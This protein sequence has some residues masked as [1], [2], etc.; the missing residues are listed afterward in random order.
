MFPVRAHVTTPT[1]HPRHWGMGAEEL[2]LDQKIEQKTD[3]MK[4]DIKETAIKAA[5]AQ[6][7]LQIGLMFIPVIGWAIG[8]LVA[9]AQFFIGKHYER[10][11]KGVIED[12]MNDIKVFAVRANEQV[13]QTA[14]RIYDEE[15]PNAIRLA[16]SPDP[17]NGLGESFWGK[18]EDKV[19]KPAATAGRKVNM[20]P[21]TLVVK[22]SRAVVGHHVKGSIK[23]LETV[24]LKSTA[25]DVRHYY[26]KGNEIAK[27]IERRTADPALAAK[28]MSGEETVEVAENKINEIKNI[29]YADINKETN[30]AIA[31]LESAEGRYE[32]R[33]QTALALRNDPSVIELRNKFEAQAR[34]AA[35]QAQ[36]QNAKLNA[37]TGPSLNTTTALVGTAL[38][39]G[40][41]FLF[42]R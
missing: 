33:K 39:A 13:T 16:V 20:I 19:L 34:Q 25:E 41:A 42:M 30:A 38:A 18:L 11:M 12:G 4:K 36:Q 37:A 40:A 32:I 35:A 28:L 23:A 8:A 15:Y 14:S 29:V 10:K 22:G 1:F 7:S 26:D 6:M 17:I 24:G 5:A 31:K 2:T 21:V 27:D 9:L 3:Q